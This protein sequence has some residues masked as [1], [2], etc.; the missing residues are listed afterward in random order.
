MDKRYYIWEVTIPTSGYLYRRTNGTFVGD[1]L[2]P[3]DKHILCEF[4]ITVWKTPHV[5]VTVDWKLCAE[6]PEVLQ[7]I[8]KRQVFG[9]QDIIPYLIAQRKLFA[10]IGYSMMVARTGTFLRVQRLSGGS[11]A[12]DLLHSRENKVDFDVDFLEKLLYL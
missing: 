4:E 3:V 9:T 5:F 10:Q 12:D 7:R 6:V 8:T 11:T 1:F 2:E